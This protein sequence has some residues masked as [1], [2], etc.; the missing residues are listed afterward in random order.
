MTYLWKIALTAVSGLNEHWNTGSVNRTIVPLK[1]TEIVKQL[2]C[3]AYLVPTR[4]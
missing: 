2:R 3:W 4:S 1:D